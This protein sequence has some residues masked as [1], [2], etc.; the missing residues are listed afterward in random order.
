MLSYELHIC[1]LLLVD[2]VLVG[3][4]VRHMVRNQWLDHRARVRLQSDKVLGW[5]VI[6]ISQRFDF[7]VLEVCFLLGHI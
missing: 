4:L 6:A 1:Q 3:E 2:N 5:S 7:A